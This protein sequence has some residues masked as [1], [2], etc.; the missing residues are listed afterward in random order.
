ML[1]AAKTRLDNE[2][3]QYL[4]DELYP[5]YHDDSDCV[6]DVEEDNTLHMKSLI[7]IFHQYCSPQQPL[8]QLN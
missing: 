1:I 8:S 6:S 3:G 4:F 7:S 5:G 2:I